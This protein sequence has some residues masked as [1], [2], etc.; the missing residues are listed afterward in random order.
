[1]TMEKDILK[2][3]VSVLVAEIV[4]KERE[5]RGWTLYKL[6]Q[7]SGVPAGN[8][9]RI[10]SGIYCPRVDTVIRVFSALGL[11]VKAVQPKSKET[12]LRIKL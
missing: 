3:Q 1:M 4:K 9:C 5:K 11:E 12:N 10:E 2:N 7:T 6:S 8:L